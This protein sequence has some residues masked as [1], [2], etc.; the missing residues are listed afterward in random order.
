MAFHGKEPPA[1]APTGAGAVEDAQMLVLDVGRVFE[2]HGAA[3]VDVGGLDFFPFETEGVQHVE[4]G[5]VQLVGFE[6]QGID[7][8]RFAQRPFVKDEA[9]V[10]GFR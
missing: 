8:K 4:R 5:I 1:D 2:R 10:E 6:A 3:D 7:A 9:D